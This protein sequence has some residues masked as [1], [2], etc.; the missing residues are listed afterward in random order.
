[1]LARQ[2][3]PSL[4]AAQTNDLSQYLF[5]TAPQEVRFEV[6]E[7]VF[8][9]DHDHP[10]ALGIFLCCALPLAEKYARRRAYRV[11]VS[12]SDWQFEVMYDGAVT[13][14]VNMFQCNRPLRDGEHA[15]RRY[16]VR[17][18]VQGALLAY[19]GRGENSAVRAVADLA[20][21]PVRTLRK[22]NQAEQDIITRELLDQ[23]T[24][25]PHLTPEAAA[26][27]QCIHSLGPDV[28]LKE[29]AAAAKGGD[30]DK[31]MRN[32]GVRPILNSTAIAEAMGTTRTVINQRLFKAR[33]T[34]HGAFNMD[35][36]LFL[37]H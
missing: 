7:A 2:R 32:R 36:K 29:H 25:L 20:Q 15:F 5:T 10:D 27:L 37:T 17:V 6:A 1:L 12:P 22:R 18:S 26:T 4:D 33:A 19:F 11:F 34:L 14:A 9:H 28:A 3:I 16:L 13:S 31:W 30:V 8:L 35:G 21:I 23:I 24:T